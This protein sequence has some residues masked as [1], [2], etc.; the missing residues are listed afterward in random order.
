MWNDQRLAIVRGVSYPQPDHSHF[1]SMDIWQ[2]A[3]PTNRSRPAGSAAGSTPPATTRCARS[4]SGRCCP[5]WRSAP[6]R[7][8]PPFP[9]TAGAPAATVRRATMTAL[10]QTTH[11]TPRRCRM[12]RAAYRATQTAD[13][14][15][16]AAERTPCRDRLTARRRNSLAAQLDTVA[17]VRQGR[18]ADAGVHGAASAASTP[19]PT[20]AAP[21]SDCCSTLDEA[22]TAVPARHGQ[23]PSAA[24]TSCVMAYSEFGRRVRANASQGTDHGTAGPVFVAGAPVQGRLLRRRAQPD[25][26]RRRRPETT[27]DFRDIY[28][29]LLAHTARRRPRPVG[30]RRAPQPRLPLTRKHTPGDDVTVAKTSAVQPAPGYGAPKLPTLLLGKVGGGTTGPR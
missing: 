28:H 5:R 21:S 17:A 19:T 30:R 23:R 11:T 16:R 4:T 2:T 22:L 15:V 25:R 29:E 14:D 10:G 20:S 3:S 7:P 1:R 18:R 12:V 9:P 24:R 8:P 6:S 13:A 27:T 26:P